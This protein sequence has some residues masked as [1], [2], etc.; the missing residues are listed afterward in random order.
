M[1]IFQSV[2]LLFLIDLLIQTDLKI[3]KQNEGIE[4][5]KKQ[6]FLNKGISLHEMGH[7]YLPMY[8]RYILDFCS[9]SNLYFFFN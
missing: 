3:K 6:K 2:V 5:M 8:I 1:Y 9:V 7:I 4:T